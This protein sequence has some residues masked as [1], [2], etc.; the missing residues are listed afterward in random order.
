MR[1]GWQH[2]SSKIMIGLAVALSLG[3]VGMFSGLG[4][5]SPNE[6]AAQ[7]EGRAIATVDGMKITNGDIDK[8]LER[9]TNGIADPRQK[10][11]MKAGIFQSYADLAIKV[12]A[13]K[14]AG[15]SVSSQELSEEKDRLF[16]SASGTQLA[17]LSDEDK[18]TYEGRLKDQI[19]DE[20]DQIRDNLLVKKWQ[21]SLGKNLDPNNLKIDPSELEVR[22]RHILLKVKDPKAPAPPKDTKPQDL[23]LPDAEAKA[24]IEK[25]LTEAKAKGADFAALARKYSQD[26]SAS[27]GGDLGWFGQGRMVPEF[28]KAAFALQPGQISGVVKSPF[29]YHI[30]KVEDRR[31]SDQ[32]KQKL[33]SDYLDKARKTTHYDIREEDIAGV[34]AMNDAAKDKAGSKERTADYQKAIDHFQS[35][36]VKDPANPGLLGLLGD[37]YGKQYEDGGKKDASLRDKAIAEYEKAVKVTPAPRI[38]MDLAELYKDANKK[39]EAVAELK[40]AADVAYTDPSIRYS[41]KSSFQELGEKKL[42]DEQQKLI[43]E[44]NKN[45]PQNGGMSF[46]I[47]IPASKPAPKPSSKPATKSTK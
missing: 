21:D 15:L 19:D 2:H 40:R 26:T 33:V 38:A 41:L 42:A 9:N 43:D 12:D 39:P 3:M 36:I 22:A 4:P 13:A 31:I 44:A 24:K 5:N 27:S 1:D 7:A 8:I 10:I 16:K 23:P 6:D 29:G 45:N 37:V 18:K 28:E 35:A 34:L 14:K 11:Q 30:I 32:A 20:T 25:I 47:N 17:G 46:P